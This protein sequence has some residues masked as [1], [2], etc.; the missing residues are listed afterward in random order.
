[1]GLSVSQVHLRHLNPFPSNLGDVLRRFKKVLLPELTDGHLALL[2]R[3]KY[4]VDVQSFSKII[5][6]PF[7]VS[8]LVEAIRKIHGA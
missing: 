3:A 1:M 5:G 8:E 2:L 4:L 6:Q 7:K